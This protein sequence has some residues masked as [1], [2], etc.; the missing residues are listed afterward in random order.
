MSVFSVC[1]I[2]MFLI[3]RSKSQRQLVLLAIVHSPCGRHGPEQR[4]GSK[5][6]V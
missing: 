5:I 1:S 3:F 6:D 4:N 2:F